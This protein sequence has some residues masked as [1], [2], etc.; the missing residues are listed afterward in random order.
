MLDVPRRKEGYTIAIIEM[1][2]CHG[3]SG[4]LWHSD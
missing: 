4:V 1:G 3:R 2:V